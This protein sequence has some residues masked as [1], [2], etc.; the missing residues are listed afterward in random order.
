MRHGITNELYINFHNA[1]KRKTFLNYSIWCPLCL[2]HY[3]TTSVYRMFY[4]FTLNVITIFVLITFSYENVRH[5]I[6]MFV[7]RHS[8]LQTCF[9]L[10]LKPLSATNCRTLLIHAIGFIVLWCFSYF[11]SLSN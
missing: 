5:F 1:K 6:Y 7:Y 8:H 9:E 11:Q 3:F 4:N 2:Q 10:R